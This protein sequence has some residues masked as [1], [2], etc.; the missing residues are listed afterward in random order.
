MTSKDE[1]YEAPK[2][3]AT[4]AVLD[5]EED[6]L[7][8]LRLQLGQSGFRVETFPEPDGFFKSIR[9]RVPDLIILDLMLPGTDGL[10]VCR[11]LKGNEA[12]CRIPV[13]MLTAKGDE[14]DKVL[15][16]E[17]GAD[18]YVT[19]PFSAREL[20]ARVKAV[21]RRQAR[22]EDER[23]IAVG[24]T[25]VLDTEKHEARLGGAKLDLTSTEFNILKLLAAK[26]GRVLTREQILD[27]LWGDEKIVIDRTV[28]VHIRNL[29]HKLGPEG[30]V[31][32]NVRGVGYKVET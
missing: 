32:K 19:K 29:R 7:E 3:S 28:D 20:V 31:I 8:L 9:K 4:I 12:W 15:G 14:T 6:I 21:L 13:I 17:M 5:D 16:L 26:K 30:G 18:D 2:M 23:T 22:G 10:E 25:L 27:H 24:D 1:P 11:L